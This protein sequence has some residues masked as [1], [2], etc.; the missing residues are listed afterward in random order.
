MAASPTVCGTAG[1]SARGAAAKI[2]NCPLARS[3]SGHAPARTLSGA[4]LSTDP[5]CRGGH[6]R[7]DRTL[8]R[9]AQPPTRFP[10]SRSGH[11]LSRYPL[12]SR[13]VRTFRG[14]GS[15]ADVLNIV[16]D[17]MRRPRFGS[18][19][20]AVRL[21]FRR[22]CDR[23]AAG[24]AGGALV[25]F[26][27]SW[28]VGVLRV[29]RGR[30]AARAPGPAVRAGRGRHPGTARRRDRGPSTRSSRGVTV[31]RGLTVTSS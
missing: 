25:G 4:G 21:V 13:H 12:D 31:V 2:T 3:L 26:A 7:L 17:Q 9:G 6:N 22:A 24:G 8:W 23:P 10:A 14:S 11:G 20:V 15:P 5:G 29:R 18:F 27:L 1:G 19:V 28:T 30:L 16:I